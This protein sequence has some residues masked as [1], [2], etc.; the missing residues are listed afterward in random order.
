LFRNN[1]ITIF[2]KLTSSSKNIFGDITLGIIAGISSFIFLFLDIHV[3]LKMPVE[4][5]GSI[6]IILLEI[7][8]LV[9]ISGI[10]KEIY[11]RGIPFYLLK[12]KYG[13]WKAFFFGNICYT[14]L[15]WPNYGLSFFLGLIWYLFFR[16]RGSLIIPIIGHGLCNLLGVLARAGVLSIVGIEPV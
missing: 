7:V 8:S 10:F 4:K 15:D 6:S 14:I 11:F 1:D 9:I 2:K 16:K 12:N 13:E 3:L 5:T